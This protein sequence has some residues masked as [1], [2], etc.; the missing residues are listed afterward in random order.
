M[1]RELPLRGNLSPGRRGPFF[2]EANAIPSSLRLDFRAPTLDV[3][4]TFEGRDCECAFIGSSGA[5]PSIN[6][7]ALC[8]AYASV[9]RTIRR[10][11]I[12]GADRTLHHCQIECLKTCD[13]VKFV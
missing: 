10:T 12:V 1:A 4:T 7:L 8:G 6:V 9:R 13:G 11:A 3:G 5:N 2:E